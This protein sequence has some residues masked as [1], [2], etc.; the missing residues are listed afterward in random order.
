MYL[1]TACGRFDGPTA[2]SPGATL[3][4]NPGVGGRST[5]EERSARDAATDTGTRTESANDDRCSDG[6]VLVVD[7]ERGFADAVALWLD[8]YEVEVAYDGDE[9]LDAY[10]PAVDVILLDRRMPTVS[11]DDVLRELRDR[12]A[13]VRVAMMTASE[14]NVE[15]AALP[16]DEYLQKPL[17][18]DEIREVVA[19]LK[20]QHAYPDS[21]REYV[22]V[23]VRLSELEATHSRDQLTES[24]AY[25]ALEERLEDVRPAAKE[26]IDRLSDADAE[27]LR[28]YVADLERDSRLV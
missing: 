6:T 8:D 15:S 25:A 3:R 19:T 4:A 21:V 14:L 11:G 9:A 12:D 24:D 23:L 17:D 1:T 28:S 22:S 18:Q 26:A 5:D 13:D 20:R 2:G 10:T 16:F 27:F 7:D